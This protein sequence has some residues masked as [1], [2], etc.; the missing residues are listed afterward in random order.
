MA[1]IITR[2]GQNSTAIIF[3]KLFDFFCNNVPFNFCVVPIQ[4]LGIPWVKMKIRMQFRG[5]GSKIR[6]CFDP[7]GMGNAKIECH[8]SLR[9]TSALQKLYSIFF[10]TFFL[11]GFHIIFSPI[12]RIKTT[13]THFLQ[14]ILIRW[15]RVGCWVG[16]HLI[17]KKIRNEFS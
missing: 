14:S 2:K 4:P 10:Q 17:S 9:Y 3:L 15:N 8:I 11:N 13:S 12:V 16:F 6:C 1:E 5:L 7:G